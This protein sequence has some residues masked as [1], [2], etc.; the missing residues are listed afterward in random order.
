MDMAGDF[1]WGD[2]RVKSLSSQDTFGGDE[3]KRK[4]S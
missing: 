1:A 3:Y 4:N 2:D